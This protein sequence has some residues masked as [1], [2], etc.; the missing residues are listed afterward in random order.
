MT[1]NRENWKLLAWA[2][3][4]MSVGE[5]PDVLKDWEEAQFMRQAKPTSPWGI[6]WEL[7]WASLTHTR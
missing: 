1:A 5:K 7:L 3:G 6:D 4:Y 2:V